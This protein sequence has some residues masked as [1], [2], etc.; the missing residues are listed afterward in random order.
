VF[1]GFVDDMSFKLLF[2]ASL[3]QNGFRS[4]GGQTEVAICANIFDLQ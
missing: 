1:E 2:P 4:G 3:M